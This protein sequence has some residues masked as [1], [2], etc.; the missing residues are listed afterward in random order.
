MI[1]F[2]P[3]PKSHDTGGSSQP[4]LRGGALVPLVRCLIW[5][6]WS[7]G[8]ASLTDG[9]LAGQDVGRTESVEELD[10]AA[11]LWQFGKTG[12][13]VRIERLLPF[14]IFSQWSIFGRQEPR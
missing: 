4:H 1:R 10:Q 2:R 13:G 12:G 9:R 7:V 11:I 6:V 8:L 14:A 3:I 5:A